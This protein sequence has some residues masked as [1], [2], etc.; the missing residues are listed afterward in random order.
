ME[1]VHNKL[2]SE[3]IVEHAETTPETTEDFSNI[4]QPT[5]GSDKN[6]SHILFDKAATKPSNIRDSF[7]GLSV[8]IIVEEQVIFYKS[9]TIRKRQFQS[10]DHTLLEM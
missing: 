3:D 2:N 9:E 6:L 1:Q 5:E 4:N 10:I 8:P 7:D